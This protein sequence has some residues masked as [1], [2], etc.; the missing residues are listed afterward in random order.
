MLSPGD[1]PNPGNELE[2]LMSPALA[3]RQVGSLPIVPPGK[4]T[5]IYTHIY[6]F[7]DF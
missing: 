3:H 4:S 6:L 2:S 1:L 5:Y 7:G